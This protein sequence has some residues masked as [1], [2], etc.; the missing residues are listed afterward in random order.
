MALTHYSISR[1]YAKDPVALA[2]FGEGKIKTH[3]GLSVFARTRE[4]FST[5]LETKYLKERIKNY[6]KPKNNV[7]PIYLHS[8]LFSP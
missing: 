8:Q 1:L 5:S 4:I 6:S 7:H 2:G 3:L